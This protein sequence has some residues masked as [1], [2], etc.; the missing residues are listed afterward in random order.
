MQSGKI[1]LLKEVENYLS[2]DLRNKADNLISKANLSLM[3][4]LIISVLSLLTSAGVGYYVGR[5]ILQQLGGEP[6]EIEELANEIA[7]GNLDLKMTVSSE[8]AVGVYRAMALMRDQLTNVIE[9]DIQDIVDTAKEGDLSKRISLEDKDGFYKNLSTGINELVDVNERV[10]NDTVRMFSAMAEG[11]LSYTID[12]EYQGAFDTL[13]QDANQ[14]VATLTQVIEGDI[15][16]IVDRSRQGDL[17]QRIS[18]E[19]KQG[20]FKNLSSGVN[21]LVSVSERVVEDTVRM[22]AALAGGDLTKSIEANYKGS[23]GQL[24]DDANATVGK[25]TEIIT[26]IR[27]SAS[28]VASGAQEISGG[29][30]DL[31][32]RTEE[33]ASALEETAA[34]MEEMTSS[35]RQSADNAKN[36]SVLASDAQTKAESGGEVVAKAVSAMGEINESSSKI[37]D[38]IGVID[39]IAFQT[40]LLALNA[41]VEAARAGEQGRGFAVVAAEVRNLAQRSAG[42]AKEIKELIRDSVGKVEDGSKLVNDS[43]D[44]LN[45]IVQAV[46]Q[47][48]SIINDISSSS[49]EQSDGID[50]VNKAVSQMDETTQ[51]NAALVE[52]A[53]AASENMAEQASLMNELMD[54]FTIDDAPGMSAV[55]T[56]VE[57]SESNAKANTAKPK[58]QVKIDDSAD[59][60]KDGWEE[61]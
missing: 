42:A 13:K 41:A 31:S 50:Q 5:G 39:E 33:Q 23:F 43:G 15:Q 35:V 49:Q 59:T 22:F 19:D 40:N 7:K 60:D 36:A 16:D 11:D 24:K 44:T 47:V 1:N 58:K 6:S 28:S 34:S 53:S 9:T 20:F 38:I 32:Q 21:D 27:S 4:S 45:E 18:V 51:Q 46:Q 54:F 14:T 61:F 25:L 17:S 48:S 12:A 56:P 37:S 26:E 2:D 29:N 30:L 3:M 8:Q 10:I 52:E 55:H 57:A